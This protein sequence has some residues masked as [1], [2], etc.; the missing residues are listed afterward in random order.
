[1]FRGVAE[2]GRESADLTLPL[3]FGSFALRMFMKFVLVRSILAVVG[4]G[5]FK[6]CVS[7]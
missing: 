2:L 4:F 7:N 5:G 3:S 1:M 6:V